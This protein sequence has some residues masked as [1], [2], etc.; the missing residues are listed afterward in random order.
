MPASIIKQFTDAAAP[1]PN[2]RASDTKA[3]D[4]KASDIGA[5]DI[6]AS[7]TGASHTLIKLLVGERTFI[8]TRDTLIRESQFFSRHL[9]QQR[10]T[11]SQ[12]RLSTP[13]L[14]CHLAFWTLK[15]ID[16]VRS[17]SRRSYR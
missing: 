1:I 5:S 10:I 12:G 16:V 6:G 8:T 3:S 7:Q 9:H 13:S 4:T 17:E 2:T 15:P 11:S 14:P